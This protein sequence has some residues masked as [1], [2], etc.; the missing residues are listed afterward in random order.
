MIK[1]EKSLNHGDP[2]N[3]L[4]DSDRPLWPFIEIHDTQTQSRADGRDSTS[5]VVSTRSLSHAAK[6]A[7]THPSSRRP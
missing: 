3:R 1:T 6:K 7:C 5:A 2:H 4:A